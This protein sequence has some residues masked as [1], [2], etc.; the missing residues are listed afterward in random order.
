MIFHSDRYK[1][2]RN[3]KPVH[4][5]RRLRPAPPAN[6]AH[7]SPDYA[8]SQ[9]SGIATVREPMLMSQVGRVREVLCA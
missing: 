7:D 5:S 3:V 2:I 6:D 4:C 8:K 9:A 1:I